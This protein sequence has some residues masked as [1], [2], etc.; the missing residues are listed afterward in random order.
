MLAASSQ[1]KEDRRKRT[2]CGATIT[3][4][5]LTQMRSA[6]VKAPND[7]LDLKPR[8]TQPRQKHQTLP[9]QPLQQLQAQTSRRITIQMALHS[10]HPL[11]ITQPRQ[12][13]NSSSTLALP[14]IWCSLLPCSRIFAL[15]PLQSMSALETALSFLTLRLHLGGIR[16]ENVFL[17][18][19]LSCNLISVRSTPS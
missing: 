10:M 12:K 17:V 2:V 13:T 18:P 15:F 8:Q 5:R 1:G 4:P 9:L 3:T 7:H 14:I 11:P 19:G 6:T 16:L